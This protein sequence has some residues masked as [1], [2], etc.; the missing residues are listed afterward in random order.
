MTTIERQADAE[1][2]REIGG[3]LSAIATTLGDGV[4]EGR[5]VMLPDVAVDVFWG[6]HDCYARVHMTA[7]LLGDASP[8]M[9]ELAPTVHAEQTDRIDARTG[10]PI[11]AIV[12]AVAR[13]RA[14]MREAGLYEAKRGADVYH[15]PSR[16]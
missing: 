16:P 14:R 11:R 7:D 2:E 1:R 9:A 8:R 5:S 15:R 3:L 4:V 6:A 10:S 12:R 13:M